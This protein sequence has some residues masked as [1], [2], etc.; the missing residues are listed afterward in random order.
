MSFQIVV[1][2]T[3]LSS[4][5]AQQHPLLFKAV[6]PLFQNVTGLMS[7]PNRF[8]MMFFYNQNILKCLYI[9]FLFEFFSKSFFFVFGDRFSFL[10]QI[11]FTWD[12]D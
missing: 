9:E 7:D 1:F 6:F 3:L 11:I 12:S 5:L 8:E 2:I 4:I 10:L